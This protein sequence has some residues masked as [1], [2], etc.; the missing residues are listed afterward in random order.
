MMIYESKIGDVPV[1]KA[2]NYQTSY[3]NPMQNP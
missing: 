2:L 1:R 3:I